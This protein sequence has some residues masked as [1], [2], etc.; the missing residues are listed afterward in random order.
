MKKK[1]MLRLNSDIVEKFNQDEMVVLSG[2]NTG[3]LEDILKDLDI[4]VNP[5]CTIN[6]NNVAGCACK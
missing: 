2:G 1:V 6:N 5:S 4:E 3:W